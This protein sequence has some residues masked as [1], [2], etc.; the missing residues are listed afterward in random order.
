M[1]STLHYF[2]TPWAVN[3]DVGVIPEATQPDGSLSFNQGYPVGYQTDPGAGGEDIPRLQFNELMLFITQAIQILQQQ[4]F[5]DFIASADNDSAP[6]PYAEN[7]TVRGPDGNNYFSLID[8]NTDTPPSSNWGLVTYVNPELSGVTK[9]YYG[10]T[11]PNGY[12]WAN[13]ATIGSASSGA[14]GRANADTANLFTLLWGSIPNSTLPIQNSDGSAGTRGIS[15]P[16]DFAANKRLPVPDRRERVAAGL[17]TMGATTDPARMT[18]AGCGFSPTT[19]CAAGGLEIV[20]LT[21]NQNGTHA[22]SAS[23]S[24]IGDHQH[25]LFSNV[26]AT[27]LGAPL[28]DSNS[29]AFELSS[30]ASTFNY[31]MVSFSGAG[32]TDASLALSSEDG[33]HTHAITIGNSGLGTAHQNTQPTIIA[34]FIIKL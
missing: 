34:N 15:A 18:L 7:A 23:A 13:G 30:G 5:P 24:T 21:A 2:R 33:S 1:S 14:T 27:T 4:G 20:A 11:L 17:G 10:S 28:T 9:E 12:V 8:G 31:Q 32:P 3:G 16:A 29:A 25:L 6:Y 22:H 19:L 26:I